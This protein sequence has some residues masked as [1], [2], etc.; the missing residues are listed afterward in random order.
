MNGIL[1][2][3]VT[4]IKGIIIQKRLPREIERRRQARATKA[5]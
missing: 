1:L 2:A 3:I 4:L 5:S